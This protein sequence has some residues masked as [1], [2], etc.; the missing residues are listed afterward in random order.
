MR[1]N[2][3]MEDK[4]SDQH[5]PLFFMSN[6]YLQH[7]GIKGMKWGIRRYQN[8][9]GSLTP[10]GQKRYGLDSSGRMSTNRS[11]SSV[12]KR[13]KSDFNS[14]SSKEFRNKY[15]ASKEA[16]AKRVKK[17]GDPYK[18]TINTLEKRGASK[19]TINQVKK[20][21]KEEAN[22]SLK[23]PYKLSK[24]DKQVLA[25]TALAGIGATAIGVY[26][27]NKG[28]SRGTGDPLQEVASLRSIR[29][30]LDYTNKAIGS[31]GDFTLS[32]LE[33]LDLY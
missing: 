13:V 5:G 31:I 24:K 25:A 30:A 4:R 32:D 28:M 11:D 26:A 7:H 15:G 10:E 1:H 23:K 18:R 19:E 2:K 17:H 16:Y 29:E 3:G 33:K 8:P 21:A 12:T 20:T 14:M 27:L 6:L 9:D 22:G